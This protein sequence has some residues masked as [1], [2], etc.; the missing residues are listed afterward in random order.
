MHRTTENKLIESSQ[1]IYLLRLV[2]PDLAE[3]PNQEF[4]SII[5]EHFRYL[6]S[7]LLEDILVLAG[8]CLDKAFGVVIFKAETMDDAIIIMND[9]PAIVNGVMAWRDS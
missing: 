3:N 8:P 1:Y 6:Q 9:D 4:D 2:N 7:L 5:G